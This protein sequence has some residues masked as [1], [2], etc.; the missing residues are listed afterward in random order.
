[1]KVWPERN[2]AAV[3]RI[4]ITVEIKVRMNE[5]LDERA[6]GWEWNS[7]QVG[8]KQ[9]SWG[10]EIVIEINTGMNEISHETAIG[11]EWNSGQVGMKQ[12]SWGIEIVIEIN[13]GMNEI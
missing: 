8:M 13:A 1:M 7:G 10:I 9:W 6:V 4:E 3:G 5:I 11:W 12:W 2:E